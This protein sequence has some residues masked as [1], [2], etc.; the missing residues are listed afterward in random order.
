MSGLRILSPVR[1]LE[2]EVNDETG[3]VERHISELK[4]DMTLQPRVFIS[5]ESGN[6]LGFYYLPDGA[7]L[8]VEEDTQIKA[9]TVI[10]KLAKAAARTQDITGGLPVFRNSLKLAV[11]KCLQYWLR[12]PVPFRLKA[13]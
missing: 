1:P 4:S 10:A 8:M 11:P 3:V 13:C 7:Q 2:E 9:G 12:S 6:A 5:D